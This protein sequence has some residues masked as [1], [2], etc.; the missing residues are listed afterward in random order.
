M[1]DVIRKTQGLYISTSL[2]S[3]NLAWVRVT[4]S[5]VSMIVFDN[6]LKETIRVKTDTPNSFSHLEIERAAQGMLKDYVSLL[7]HRP[8]LSLATVIAGIEHTPIPLTLVRSLGGCLMP[9][10]VGGTLIS[11]RD[12]LDEID[13]NTMREI[14]SF[15]EANVRNLFI[16]PDVRQMS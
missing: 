6:H 3:Y 9:L 7:C 15:S 12:K 14:I 1:A 16:R 5:K 8:F 2:E 13:E 10:E 4:G 11:H